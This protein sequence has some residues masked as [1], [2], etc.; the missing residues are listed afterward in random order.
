MSEKGYGFAKRHPATE[1]PVKPRRRSTALFAYRRPALN[2]PSK[3]TIKVLQLI[4]NSTPTHAGVH[5]KHPPNTHPWMDMG[6]QTGTHTHRRTVEFAA[7]NHRRTPSWD[8]TY[9]SDCNFGDSRPCACMLLMCTAT[10]ALQTCV[11]CTATLCTATLCTAPLGKADL[12][13][14]CS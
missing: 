1:H 4:R 14:A 10:L 8:M 2:Y 11:M 6:T 13:R 7:P 3:H 5:G 9:V 12:A